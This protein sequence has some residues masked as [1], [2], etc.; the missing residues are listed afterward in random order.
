MPEHRHQENH[1]REAIILAGGFGTRLKEALPNLPKSLAPVAGRPFLFY[2]INYLRSQSVTRFIFSLGYLHEQ[3]E[4]FL[5]KEFSTLDYEIVIEQ[6]P[7]GTGGGI[8]LAAEKCVSKNVIVTNGDTLFKAD[9]VEMIRLHETEEGLCSLALKPMK[10]FD[11]Y[12]VVELKGHRVISFR[13]KKYYTQGLINGGLY[14]LNIP[15]FKE[16]TSLTTFSFEKDFLE[17]NSEQAKIIGVVQ[18]EYFI[19]IGIPADYQRAQEEFRK[20]PLD[21][22]A[23]DYSWTLFIDRDGVINHEKKDDYILH[24]GEFR[25][26]DGAKDAFRIF[27][28]KFSKIIIIS[29]Q[30][31]VGRELMTD[32][33]LQEIHRNMQEEI[34]K[35]GGRIDRIYY[36]TSKDNRHICRKPNPGMAFLAR[37]D[38]PEIDFSRSIMIGNKPSDMLFG[39]YAGL[40][41][42]FLRTTNPGF[43]SPHQDVDLTYDSLVDF[44]KAL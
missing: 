24:W 41:T 23:I 31:G 16:L 3:I 27:A 20:P 42:V 44:A 33:D 10:D 32:A 8:R 11:R 13:E 25:F 39:R 43:G 7:M 19:D 4:D 5:A 15:L 38:Y 17:K 28:K 40:H 1:V 12:G 26:Y 29:N 22:N 37:K 21:L 2:I 35:S 36:C 14:I 30:R 18:D 6:E 34:E 9:I